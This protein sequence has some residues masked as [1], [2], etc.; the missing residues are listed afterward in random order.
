MRHEV[1]TRR[2]L[3]EIPGMDSVRVREDAFRGAD[4]QPLPAKIYEPISPIA[5][6]AVAIV[7]GLPDA[8][9]E[10]HV[11]CKFMEMEWAIGM[12]RLIAAS[13]MAAVTHSNREAQPDA[14]AL[15]KHLGSHHRK[16]GIWSTSGHGPVALTAA[17]HAACAVLNNPITKDFCPDT[18]L[19]IIRAGR[20]ETAGL[21][22]ALDAFVAKAV[23]DNKPLTFVNYPDAP[24][25]YELSID[26]A[27]T[28]RVLQQGLDFLRSHLM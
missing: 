26:T 18:P 6:C 25:S 8:G 22:V 9:F 14:I 2:L 13:G 21:N 20:D 24:H 3:Y 1:A 28:R 16:V 11:G 5:D 4:G 27:E 15:M 10:Q 19:F 12:A 23:A 7:A 17:S